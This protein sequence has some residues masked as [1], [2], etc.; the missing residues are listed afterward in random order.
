MSDSR[1]DEK[2]LEKKVL[3]PN[4]TTEKSATQNHGT[5]GR[6]LNPRSAAVGLLI[7][8]LDPLLA[9]KHIPRVPGENS[10]GKAKRDGNNRW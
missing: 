9:P 10:R 7:L 6:I 2:Y 3:Q 4:R 8:Q 1:T 5:A